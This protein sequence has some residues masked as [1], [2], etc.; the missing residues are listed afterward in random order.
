MRRKCSET[1]II[2]ADIEFPQK[3]TFNLFCSIKTDCYLYYI[4]SFSTMCFR[5]RYPQ[6]DTQHTHTHVRHV[7]AVCRR[8]SQHERACVWCVSR[9]RPHILTRHLFVAATFPWLLYPCLFSSKCALVQSAGPRTNRP[10]VQS[11]HSQCPHKLMIFISSS[12]N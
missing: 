3:L 8:C 2:I 10:T 1:S 7:L 9:P 12:S 6:A 5:A 4:F 11:I